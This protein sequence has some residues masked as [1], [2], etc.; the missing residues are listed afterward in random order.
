MPSGHKIHNL[1]EVIGLIRDI[2]WGY[3]IGWLTMFIIYAGRVW[4]VERKS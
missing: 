3:A 1:K 2:D 4:D